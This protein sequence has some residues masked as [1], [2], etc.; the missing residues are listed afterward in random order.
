MRNMGV[1]QRESGGFSAAR[2]GVAMKVANRSVQSASPRDCCRN[3]VMHIGGSPLMSKHGWC[4]AQC[5]RG[6]RSQRASNM[7]GS[8][9]HVGQQAPR[10]ANWQ[11]HAALEVATL[12][13]QEGDDSSDGIKTARRWALGNITVCF[14]AWCT[15]MGSSK[16]T[17]LKMIH[18][19]LD[20]RRAAFRCNLSEC[21]CM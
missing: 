21:K 11:A 2:P 20:G 8:I 16:P 6:N 14:Q 10:R 1:I 5:V 3:C 9:I 19:G 4:G 17:I 18:G 12:S 15:M 13:Q 7:S